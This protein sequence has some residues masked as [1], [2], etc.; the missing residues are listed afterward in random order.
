MCKSFVQ[1]CLEYGRLLY[2]G[3]A[4]SHLERLDTLQCQAASMCHCI[5]P[6]LESHWHVAAI[7]LTCRL[8]DGE[9]CGGLQSFLPQFV[10]NGT[11]RSSRLTDLSDPSQSL[12]LNNPITFKSLDSFHRSW[13]VNNM[14]HSTCQ[15]TI[16]G[17][18]HNMALCAEKQWCCH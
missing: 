14:G 10:A 11:R 17:S 5:F 15:F 2:F 8:L 18:C 12:R 4:R 13:H 3:A 16:T 6:S 9:A 1:S 7:G